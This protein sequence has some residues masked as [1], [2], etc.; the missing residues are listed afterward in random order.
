MWAVANPR[1]YWSCHNLHSCQNVRN[2]PG[3]LISA[4]FEQL[5]GSY[6]RGTMASRKVDTVISLQKAIMRKLF[7]RVH[8][9]S[10]T[11]SIL[12]HAI[13]TVQ[14][15]LKSLSWMGP[16][17]Y[18]NLFSPTP[19]AGTLPYNK[20]WTPTC[21][22]SELLAKN[23]NAD[24]L[25]IDSFCFVSTLIA[26]SGEALVS[27][28]TLLCNYLAGIYHVKLCCGYKYATFVITRY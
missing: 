27:T 3:F 1:C 20:S 7:A 22:C 10:I 12:V 6:H 9:T 19:N 26:A 2:T 4:P 23:D 15:K 5:H 14:T 8:G 25:L 16:G 18:L 11:R 21:T 13:C 28:C 17:F 24:A